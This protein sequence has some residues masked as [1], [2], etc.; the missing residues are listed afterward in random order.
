MAIEVKEK[1][2]LE[3]MSKK[4]EKKEKKEV[5]IYKLQLTHSS[6]D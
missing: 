3:E 2:K 1:T 6:F 5:S 4:E